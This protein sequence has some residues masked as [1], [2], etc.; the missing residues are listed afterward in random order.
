MNASP[1][2]LP[3]P[4]APAVISATGAGAV[5]LVATFVMT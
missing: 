2:A 3:M 5:E 4:A 1:I